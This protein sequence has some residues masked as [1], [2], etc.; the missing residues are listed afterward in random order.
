ME[1]KAKY[2]TEQHWFFTKKETFCITSH[3]GQP[4]SVTLH[5]ASYD[6]E[7][8]GLY[9]EFERCEELA[10]VLEEFLEAVRPE[11]SY[12]VEKNSDSRQGN[13]D[14]HWKSVMACRTETTARDRAAQLMRNA[15]LNTVY[16]VRKVTK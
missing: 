16:R 8:P 10:K 9:L 4:G 12:V 3:Q 5:R 7:M 11:V 14:L 15:P 2:Y 13:D 1:G 6:H